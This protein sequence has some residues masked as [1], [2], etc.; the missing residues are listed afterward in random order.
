MAR[1]SNS[2]RNFPQ[3]R[4]CSIFLRCTRSGY[5]SMRVSHLLLLLVTVYSSYHR[6][7]RRRAHGSIKTVSSAHLTLLI[8]LIPDRPQVRKSTET[9]VD[10]DS[11]KHSCLIINTADYCQTTALEV[12]FQAEYQNLYLTLYSL[13]K[14]SRAR[15][16][17]TIKIKSV[18]KQNVICLS[19][20]LLLFTMM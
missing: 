1:V 20:V 17:M 3:A 14:R 9:R 18:S 15:S 4:L 5:G 7:N 12:R 11:L 10:L 8:I 2:V 13:K 19:G 6:D 16:M